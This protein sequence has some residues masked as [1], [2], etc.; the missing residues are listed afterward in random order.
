MHIGER[1]KF[2]E[3]VLWTKNEIFYLF[4]L[5]I[6]PI[7]ITLLSHWSFISRFPFFLAAMLG[8]SCAFIIALK[9]NS[10]DQVRIVL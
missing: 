2:V 5:S 9:N 6:I 1:F 4:L 7:T 8:T 10:A 3:Y